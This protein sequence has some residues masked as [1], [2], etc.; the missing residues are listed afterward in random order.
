MQEEIQLL[1]KRLQDT[2][3]VLPIPGVISTSRRDEDL[4][5]EKM[6]AGKTWRQLSEVELDNAWGGAN[7]SG[8]L[9]YLTLESFC[10][11]LPFFLMQAVSQSNIETMD[12]LL[13]VLGAYK[14][15]VPTDWMMEKI[16]C[17][18]LMQR[19]AVAFGLDICRKLFSKSY[20]YD[21][22]E[23]LFSGYWGRFLVEES[24]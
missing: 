8:V 4:R 10:Y 11:Y 13:G 23:L 19:Q 15:G 17:L 12:D 1:E 9:Y 21:P 24:F 6:F 18:N 22:F 7:I 5:A 3:P 16:G 20:E 14:R 2:F